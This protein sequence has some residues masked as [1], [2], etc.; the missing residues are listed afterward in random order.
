[1]PRIVVMSDTHMYHR[2][3]T[4]PEGDVVV[5][6][7]DFTA[8]GE[9]SDYDDF[10]SWYAELPHQHKILVAGNHD[11]EFEEEPELAVAR[12]GAGIVYLQDAGIV[13]DRVKFWGS[14]WQ[15]AFNDWAFNLPRGIAL[16]RKWNLIPWDTD[17]LV[18]HGQPMTVLDYIPGSGHVGCADLW[19]RVGDIAPRVHAFGHIHEGS[20]MEL[21]DGTQF[22][23]ASICDGQYRPLNPARVVDL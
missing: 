22:V 19:K 14:P 18:T 7:G 5:H 17:V 20:G 1:M 13:I 2:M 4:V 10:F 21:R 3:L 23:N 15:P 11:R 8:A 16:A 12:L 9:R 6:C